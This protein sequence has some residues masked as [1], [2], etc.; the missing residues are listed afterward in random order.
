MRDAQYHGLKNAPGAVLYVPSDWWPAG[1]GTTTLLVRTQ[2]PPERVAEPIRSEIRQLNPEIEVGQV[3]TIASQVHDLLGPE[4][5][6]A[7]ATGFAMLLGLLLVGIGVYGSVT[8][9]VNGR[10]NEYALRLALGARVSQVVW[11]STRSL[12]TVLVAGTT[13][14]FLVSLPLRGL[15]KGLLF[16]TIDKGGGSVAVSIAVV[17]VVAAVAASGPLARLRRFDLAGALRRD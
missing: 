15:T 1:A 12:A 13:I 8:Q 16:G 11:L 10:L 9:R 14:G 3:T 5:M 4:R 17:I 6:L 7:Q 2:Q